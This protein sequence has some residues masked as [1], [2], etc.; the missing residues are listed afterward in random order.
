MRST[1]EKFLVLKA[2]GVSTDASRDLTAQDVLGACNFLFG[3]EGRPPFNWYDPL[4]ERWSKVQPNGG[5]PVGT[6]WTQIQRPSAKLREIISATPATAGQTEVSLRHDYLGRLR[7]GMDGQTLPAASSAIWFGRG[8]NNLESPVFADDLFN[9]FAEALNLTGDEIRIL[10][11][12]PADHIG[13]ETDSDPDAPRY[14]ALLPKADEPPEP[15]TPEPV[16]DEVFIDDDYRWTSAYTLIPLPDADVRALVEKVL[17][18]IDQANLVFSDADGLIERCVV[19][20]LTGHLILRGPPG[21]GKTTL[22]RLLARAFD[23]IPDLRT[24]TADWTTYEVI[25]GLRPTS[26]NHLTPVL[27]CVPEAVLG[28]AGLIRKKSRNDDQ[29]SGP[30]HIARW[31]I[32][33]ELNRADIDRAIG[34]LYTVLSS[35]DMAHLS[36]TPI[37]L[38]FEE[39]AKRQLWVPARFRLIGTMNDV[40]TSFVNALSQ[41][42]TRRFQF[43]Y[44]GVPEASQQPT[45]LELSRRQAQDWIASQYGDLFDSSVSPE[46]FNRLTSAVGIAIE[47]LT[48]WLRY[49]ER[50]GQKIVGWPLGTAQIVD[51]WKTICLHVFSRS[52][53]SETELL[54]SFDLS[55]ADRVIPQMGTLR[56]SQLR[57]FSNYLRDEHPF[58]AE[59]ARAVEHLENPQTV[60]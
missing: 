39:G 46:R 8:R 5:W 9:D 40:D 30:E 4:T 31:L 25:G 50:D 6:V 36:R 48:T 53:V 12:G 2:L 19:G 37:D 11:G 13:V 21:T 58:L 1:I 41:G 42:L 51:L 55:F 52:D 16:S 32:I 59:S 17:D 24:A 15:P 34:G 35:T 3:V 27:G 45:E 49:G 18:L 10:F 57:A 26:D 54:R 44:V 60:R 23:A 47:E 33:D 14:G 28:C 20:L 43:V 7:A 56:S 38:W 22:A 29:E